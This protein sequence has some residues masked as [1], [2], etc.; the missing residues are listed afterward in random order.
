MNKLFPKLIYAISAI[1]LG[2]FI[3]RFSTTED[4]S[5]SSLYIFQNG[6]RVNVDKARHLSL[7]TLED[8]NNALVNIAKSTNPSVVTVFVSKVVAGQSRIYNFGPFQF[9]GPG[10]EERQYERGMGSG[11]IVRENGYILTN[12]HVVSHSDS[13]V[14]QLLGG[15]ILPAKVI[16]TDSLT[17][18]AVIKIN[19]KNLPVMPMGNSDSLKV[20]QLVMAVGSPLDPSLSNTVTLGI[21]SAKGREHLHLAQYEDYIQTD[22]AINPGNSGGALVNM[23]GTLVGIN[24]AIATESGGYQGIGFAIPVNMAKNIMEQII[25]YGKV[26]RGFLNVMI[27][28]IDPTMAQAL[29]LKE[30]QGA[31]ITQV[32]GDPAKSAGLKQGDIVLKL[33]GRD[34]KDAGQLSND[35]AGTPPGT[36]VSLTILR[37]N[38]EQEIKVKLADMSEQL[39]E[40]KYGEE[41]GGANK[42]EALLNFSVSNLSAQLRNQYGLDRNLKGVV[43]TKINR[44]SQAYQNGL[45]EGDVIL[46]AGYNGKRSRVENFDDFSK[47]LS[48]IHK[49]SAVFL[50]VYDPNRKSVLYLAFQLY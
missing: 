14:V 5:R 11:I 39:K 26:K 20:G 8:L 37:N 19:A 46:E 50:K 41:S 42:L 16:G 22:A 6:D 43:V 9:Y 3:F 34:V 45:T 21:V 33:N 49:G 38:K 30:S 25:K 48:G 32:N 27:R 7:N 10:P 23:D 44:N 28:T 18:V 1:I 13:V 29:G 24:S 40:A 12:N 31:L 2:I 4:V 36:T 17:D 47:A 35:I 15:K